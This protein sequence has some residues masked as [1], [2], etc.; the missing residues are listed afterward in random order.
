MQRMKLHLSG[1]KVP[2]LG[3][4]HDRI[5]REYMTKESQLEVE[6]MKMSM[7]TA[8]TNPN[9]ADPNKARD[10]SS[11]IKK[12]W[13]RYLALEFNTEMPEHTEKEVEMLEYYENVVKHMKPTLEKSGS[14]YNVKGLDQLFK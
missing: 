6:K 2:P 12:H 8:L 10:W 1:M 3:S 4:L 11:N 14:G 9:I 5:Y 13:A 7:L